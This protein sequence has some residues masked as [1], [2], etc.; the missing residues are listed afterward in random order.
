MRALLAP[1][2]RFLDSARGA[3]RRVRDRPVGERAALPPRGRHERDACRRAGRRVA[4]DRQRRGQPVRRADAVHRVRDLPEPGRPVPARLVAGGAD[5]P[6]L[7]D[8]AGAGRGRQHADLVLAAG[9]RRPRDR[10]GQRAVGRAA[11][12]AGRRQQPAAGGAVGAGLHVALLRPR[13]VRL[14]RLVLAPR[15]RFQRADVDVHHGQ[16]H[17]CGGLRPA[18]RRPAVDGGRA[19]LDPSGGRRDQGRPADHRLRHRSPGSRATPARCI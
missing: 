5:V 3:L 16:L 9:R 6:D 10:A 15:R 11:G 12:V 2:L 4:R 7:R 19:G 8:R 1:I 13:D 18:A 17:G 14:L